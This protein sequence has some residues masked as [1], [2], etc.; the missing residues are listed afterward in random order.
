MHRLQR[1][2]KFHKKVCKIRTHRKRV[3]KKTTKKYADSC[4]K[5]K[6]RLLVNQNVN[7]E[8]ELNLKINILILILIIVAVERHSLELTCA[9][10]TNDCLVKKSISR[11]K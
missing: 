11:P 4:L 9:F 3:I 10:A 7:Y 8:T 5:S 6:G 1:K 2:Y